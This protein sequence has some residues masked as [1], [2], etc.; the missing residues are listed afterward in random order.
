MK[1][2]TFI[3]SLL[4]TVFVVDKANAQI[5]ID[6]SATYIVIKTDGTEFIGKIIS[7]DAHEVIIETKDIG[8]VAI[9]KSSIKEIRKLKGNEVN[10][11]GSYNPDQPFATRYFITTN[12]LPIKKGDMYAQ[13][14]LFGPEIQ[15]G[16]TENLGVG[17][18]T[19]WWASPIVLS[20][21]YS[22]K[23]DDKLHV[24]VGALVGTGSWSWPSFYMAVPFAAIT[25]GDR[26]NNI[27]VSGGYGT[28]GFTSSDEV[29]NSNTQTYTTVKTPYSGGRA[30]LSIAGMATVNKKV[31]L[32]FDSFIVPD[33]GSGLAIA[34][35]MPGIRFQT[36]PNKAFQFGF[37]GIRYSETNTSNNGQ[38]T[39]EK[40][41]VPLP[42]P[43]LTWFRK[44]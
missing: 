44:I 38:K 10:G 23:L 33:D 29:Y 25:Y 2:L 31:A 34:L 41:T 22:F 30:L 43:M 3:I 11:A 39:I 15:Y 27:T 1:K 17:L 35:F 13:I 24:G 8:Q 36:N 5:T 9:P 20:A 18:M 32:V 19:S 42:I 26:K 40:G 37:A 6:T 14:N 28:V 12:G 7:N 4:L 21:K 16:V